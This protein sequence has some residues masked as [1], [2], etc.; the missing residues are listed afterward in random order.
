MRLQTA[1]KLTAM[2]KITFAVLFS[3]ILLH[4]FGQKQ[5]RIASYLTGQFNKTIYDETIGLNPWGAGLGLRLQFNSNSKLNALVEITADA[6]VASDKVAVIG[7]DGK[8]IDEVSGMLNFFAGVSY[9]PANNFFVSIAAGPSL[10]SHQT[11]FGIKPSVGTYLSKNKRWMGT[12]SYI[13]VLNRYKAAGQDFGSLSLG[14]GVK[15]F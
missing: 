15:L 11:L 14:I 2:K 6:Y 12:F 7:A 8:S 3:F 9:R 13:N 5:E 4:S 10:V 1:E